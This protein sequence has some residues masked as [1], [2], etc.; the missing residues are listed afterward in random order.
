[1]KTR[2]SGSVFSSEPAKAGWGRAAART[3]PTHHRRGCC[4]LDEFSSAESH[5]RLRS[6]GHDVTGDSGLESVSETPYLGRVERTTP[7]V[8]MQT[9]ARRHAAPPFLPRHCSQTFRSASMPLRAR[10]V[11]P[12]SDGVSVTGGVFH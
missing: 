2:C 10:H 5:V 4:Y 1:M 9:H 8:A 7:P 11:E 6:P 12:R 3:A